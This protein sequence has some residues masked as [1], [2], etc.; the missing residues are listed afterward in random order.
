MAPEGRDAKRTILGSAIGFYRFREV[1]KT[2]GRAR[3]T[4]LQDRSRVKTR[5]G[6]FRK[7][8]AEPNDA[9]VSTTSRSTAA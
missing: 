1:R 6:S 8:S 3:G 7:H 4:P 9:A 5:A 2:D